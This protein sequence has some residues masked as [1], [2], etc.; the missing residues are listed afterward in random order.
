MCIA[1]LPCAAPLFAS[2]SE[3]AIAACCRR[4]GKHHC[5]QT[6]RMAGYPNVPAFSQDMKCPMAPRAFTTPVHSQTGL[7]ASA[8]VFAEI[9]SHP[10]VSPQTLSNYRVSLMR[11]H[12]KRGPPA[13]VLI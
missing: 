7:T 9:I 5:A 3:S 1:V 4:D 12:Q 6:A 10:A 13:T 11:S 2:S 8:A